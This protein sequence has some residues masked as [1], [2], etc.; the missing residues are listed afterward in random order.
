MNTA[1]SLQNDSSCGGKGFFRLR[2]Y[3]AN[4]KFIS[5]RT[6]WK[7]LAVTLAVYEAVRTQEYPESGEGIGYPL[8]VTKTV[9]SLGLDDIIL[10]NGY[11]WIV[12]SLQE[13]KVSM[14]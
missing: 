7:V 14:A 9:I 11:E 1:F 13:V 10:P 3:F 2:K 6:M 12:T 5:S 4:F 8:P